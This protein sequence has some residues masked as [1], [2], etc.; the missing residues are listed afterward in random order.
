MAIGVSSW[1][2]LRRAPSTLMAIAMAP[3]WSASAIAERSTFQTYSS[4]QGITS[5]DGSS[6]VQDGAGAVLIS[7]EHGVFSYDGRRFVN[8]GANQGLRQGGIVYSV[9]LTSTGRIAVQYPDEVY[10]S[11][12]ASD[13]SH[14]ATSLSFHPVSH[15]GV[16]FY[17]E[18]PHR[19]APWHD[20]FALLAGEAT[21]AIV[22]S[23]G[24]T[25]RV[26]SMSHD[27]EE[28]SS[29]QGA[30]AVFS[31]GGRL[32]ETF[33]DGRVCAADPGRVRCY[34]A[35]DGLSDG[36]WVDLV[37]GEGGRVLA[38]SASAVATL[39]PASDRWSSS[40][41]PDQGGRYQA[42]PSDLGLYRTPDG[43]F[44]T[45]SVQGIDV[46]GP[47]GWTELTVADGAPSGT[48][49]DAM[50][51]GT[52]QLW[53][54]VLGR[55]LVRWVGYGHWDTLE[56]ADGLSDGFPWETARA[57]DGTLWVTTDDGVD[58][59]VR[60]GSSVHVARVFPVSSYALAAMPH[61]DIWAGYRD[62]GFR[63]IDPA[64]GSMVIVSIPAVETIV[65][66]R[67]QAV[68]I[69]TTKGLYKVDDT[70][71]PFHPVLLKA[72]PTPV[73][74]IVRDGL[75]G[76]YYL[77]GGRLHHWR[78]N[79][80]NVDV[81]GPWP[82]G[83]LEPLAMAMT[84]DGVLYVGG[85]GGLFRVILSADHIRSYEPVPTSDTGTSTIFAVMI[86][87]RGWVWTGTALGVSVYN[88]QRWVSVDADQGLLS[89]DVNEDGMREDPDG[90][91]W[92]STTRGV[93]HLRDPASL[94]VDRPLSVVISEAHIGSRPVGVARVPYTLDPLS[95]EI[96]TPNHGVE[97]GV[98]FR[99]RLSGVDAGWVASSSGIVRY[100][101]VPPGRH[102]LTVIGH[103]QL[104]HID[105]LPTTLVVDV[106]YPW[107]RRWWSEAFWIACA[108]GMIYAAARVRDRVMY[109]RQAELE[110]HVADATEQ[111]RYHAAHDRLTGLL[112]RSEIESRL[113]EK[114]AA[115][116]DS[117]DLVVALIDID[118]FKRIND[119]HGHLGGD[120]VLRA[121]GRII[122]RTLRESEYAGR[123]GGEEMLLV[124][125][126][127]DGCAAER[128]LSLNLSVRHDTFKAGD[129]PVRVTCS[130]G[131]A[132]ATRGD[133]WETLIGRADAALYEAKNGGRDR[134]IESR[135][136]HV[137]V[138][139]SG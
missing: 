8:L 55:G 62:K 63:V 90:S 60:K 82:T 93:S 1:R 71:P 123:Y 72:W 98:L 128:V 126:D 88:G 43:R 94:F 96:G 117:E 114:L 52:G 83:D 22:M 111:I 115:E 95:V 122:S 138:S 51:D 81:P 69:G 105:S 86:D 23:P 36:P 78:P 37:A 120:E 66:G 70:G 11:D 127:V 77:S 46:L 41:L 18:R 59:I 53:F 28:R 74:S 107:W 75:G 139:R 19:L 10:V 7:T 116:H 91:V 58:Q 16:S 48:I 67:N 80:T 65:P 3:C 49:V 29:L 42:Y 119:N 68:W 136:T 134:V 27:L 25:A 26:E 4:D 79:G 110:R 129:S 102:V 85:P 50:T 92:I 135:L 84:R 125:T 6:L 15:P 89:N 2:P 113:A 130:V 21:V 99:Y 13:P 12:G 108:A 45:Q 17:D 33:D 104:T 100:P 106:A 24:R 38:R 61:G 137:G 56:Q 103:D 32:W 124:L 40:P 9:A 64:T 30:M 5:L 35:V 57:A 131:V 118:H 47:G 39:D 20:G 54:H 34:G 73:E 109:A 31:V 121:M 87:H 133:N 44:I 76:V 97:R 112:N 132:W 101:F 14:P